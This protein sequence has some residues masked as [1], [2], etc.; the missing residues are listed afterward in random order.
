MVT[1]ERF[2]RMSSAEGMET[3]LETEYY[4]VVRKNDEP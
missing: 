1:V 2:I 3:E 4:A